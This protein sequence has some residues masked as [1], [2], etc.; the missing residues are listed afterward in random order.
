[1]RTTI[2]I[3]AGLVTDAMR[4]AGVKT[5]TATI[6]LGLKELLRHER[7]RRIRD[8]RGKVDIDVDTTISRSR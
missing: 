4:A 7:I 3:P 8:F 2:D 6:I 5:K 1:M